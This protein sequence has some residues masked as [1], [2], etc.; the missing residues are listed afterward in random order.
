VGIPDGCFFSG[1]HGEMG[2]SFQG[3]DG[4]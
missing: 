1:L 2:V 3:H 4:S